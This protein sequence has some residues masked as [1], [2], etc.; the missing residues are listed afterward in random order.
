MGL[1]SLQE[2]VVNKHSSSLHHC[3]LKV[4]TIM[5][6]E[7]HILTT[8]RDV[9]DFSGPKLIWDEVKHGGKVCCGP[10]ILHF[11][12][13]LEIR[14]IV[15]PEN[16]HKHTH[17][18]TVVCGYGVGTASL[19]DCSERK[20]VWLRNC[21]S[22]FLSHRAS[23][24]LLCAFISFH[25]SP[26]SPHFSSAPLL[27]SHLRCTRTF[28]YDQSDYIRA[29]QWVAARKKR[30]YGEVRCAMRSSFTLQ[31]SA[32]SLSITKLLVLPASVHTSG[33]VI[34]RGF[35]QLYKVKVHLAAWRKRNWKIR[36]RVLLWSTES[37]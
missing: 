11:K 20:T 8:S 2:T 28:R 17:T 14:H 26:S 7:S 19:S 33:R 35:L 6:S 23:S 21:M 4:K 31:L 18:H 27:S 15:I 3:C 25:F 1:G 16:I 37:L 32:L 13:C 24:H 9:A 22:W 29:L 10:M 30:C 12:L 5:Q 34:Q 36:V